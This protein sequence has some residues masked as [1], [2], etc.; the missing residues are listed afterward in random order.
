[1]SDKIS[2]FK[3]HKPDIK[4][5]FETTGT[6]IF[7]DTLTEFAQEFQEVDG[8]SEIW[9]QELEVS[10]L[11]KLWTAL[12]SEDATTAIYILENSHLLDNGRAAALF[13]RPAKYWLR[14]IVKY[15]ELKRCIKEI[16]KLYP[17]DAQYL[18]VVSQV[19]GAFGFSVG[20]KIVNIVSARHTYDALSLRGLAQNGTILEIGGGHGGLAAKCIELGVCKKYV[21][22][23]LPMMLTVS[24]HHL[25][26]AFP[27][28]AI[29]LVSPSTS[30]L[31]FGRTLE[32]SEIVLVPSDC[33]H[34]IQHVAAN[35]CFN[36]YSFSE[37]TQSTVNNYLIEIEKARIPFLLHENYKSEGNVSDRGLYSSSRFAFNQLRLLQTLPISNPRNQRDCVRELYFNPNCR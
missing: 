24:F 36:S 10:P 3:Y 5:D 13:T 1:M 23:D 6:H 12:K 9:R 4:T 8:E 7:L 26:T 32:E 29:S 20:N 21:I 16:K 28:H 33:K 14:R 18:G 27:N 11:G 19:G 15:V 31:E 34:L 2:F 37:M 30:D 35:V 25:S 22:V 17:V